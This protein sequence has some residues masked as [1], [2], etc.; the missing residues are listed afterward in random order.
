M[1]K[2]EFERAVLKFWPNATF[3]YANDWVTVKEKELGAV[4]SV[5]VQGAPEDPRLTTA[6]AA[7]E[8]LSKGPLPHPRQR[9]PDLTPAT[10]LSAVWEAL[11]PLDKDAKLRVIGALQIL[12]EGED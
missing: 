1:T 11:E 7:V 2:L 4:P 5:T 10:V 8:A 9:P 12:L 3:D 6:L